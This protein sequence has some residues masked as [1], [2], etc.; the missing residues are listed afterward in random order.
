M[1]RIEGSN[2]RDFMKTM[3]SAGMMGALPASAFA[4]HSGEGH[5]VHE[6]ASPEFDP[7]AQPQYDVRFSVIGLD[8]YHIFGITA[9]LLRGG[10]QL[11]SVYAKDDQQIAD[12]RKKFGDIKRASSEEEIL[13]DKS[14]QIVAAAPRPDLRA[15][16]GIRVMHSGKDF[17]SDKPGAISFAQLEDVRRAVK[18]TGRIFAIMF[19]ERL[20]V[21]SVIKAKELMLAG[22]IGRVIQTINIAPHKAADVP[23]PEWF[24]D[25]KHYGGILVDIGSHQADQFLNFTGST[26]ADIAASQVANTNHPEHPHFQDFGDMMIHGNGGAAYVRVDWFTPAALP[27]WGDG[28]LFV[29]G[30]DGYMEL[31]KYIDISGRP[32]ADHLFV[33]N[34]KESRYI[35]CTNVELPFGHN[36]VAD[37][38]HRTHHAQDQVATLLATELVLKAQQKAQVLHFDKA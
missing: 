20:E 31:R 32:G 7:A 27:V 23:R 14:I 9:A 37:V 21:K 36:F 13:N 26:V 22:A 30:T 35:D 28:R 18:E 11:V 25:T 8:H 19:S 12:F 24:W 6:I 10:A 33:V 3:T 17:L 1:A 29:L 2:R 5:I 16:L 38:V 15:P 4:M 34:Q